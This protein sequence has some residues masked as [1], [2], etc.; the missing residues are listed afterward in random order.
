MI[1]RVTLF[2]LALLLSSACKQIL[3]IPGD[4]SA[5]DGGSDG[6]DDGPDDGED[7][8]GTDPDGSP[9][10][11]SPGPDGAP[12]DAM[13][14]SCDGTPVGFVGFDD[15]TSIE[16]WSLESDLGC[17]MLVAGGQ[18]LIQ[19]KAPPAACSAMGELYFNLN[20]DIGLNARIEVAGNPQMSM[21]FSLI[22][23]D[24]T[25]DI[26]GRR[27]LRIE[28]NE[29][30]IRFGECTGDQCD[31]TAYGA[32]VF[33]DV[34]HQWWRFEYVA[35]EQAIYLEVAADDQKFD[36]IPGFEAVTDIEP[37]LVGCV[38]V[39]VGTDEENDTGSASFD[40]VSSGQ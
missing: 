37:E 33:D 13:E 6:P 31:E 8:D 27:R 38:G 25:V 10:D 19:Q 1:A 15:V 30:E 11:G 17:D 7:D 18:M 12:V 26:R 20:P 21:V 35:G 5:V 34:A 23:D 3:G 16:G 29:G 28:R 22:L 2:A 36:R 4:P 40:L 14:F 32:D 39:E 9:G 24:G